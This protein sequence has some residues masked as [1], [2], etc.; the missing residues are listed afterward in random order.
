MPTPIP[1]LIAIEIE[2]RLN[3]VLEADG[4]AFDLSEVVRPTRKG[5]N[6]LKRHRGVAILQGES[7]RVP[8]LDCPGNPPAIAYGLTFD[9][10]CVT[11]DSMN[12]E[13]A[14]A[15]EENEIAAVVV[16]GIT[17]PDQWH[18]MDGNA[19]DCSIGSAVPFS[20]PE[21]ELDGVTIP[22]VVTYRVSETNP[23]EVR[24]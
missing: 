17:A 21:G 10:A 11:R 22:V 19:I 23:Y 9:L 13:E 24:A 16:K 14:H 15:T 12:S 7:T 5:E 8:E 4:Y 2:A 18:T 6:W 3:A 1:E 20:S